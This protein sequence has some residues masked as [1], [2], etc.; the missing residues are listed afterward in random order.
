[1]A[2]VSGSMQALKRLTFWRFVA[3]V[4]RDV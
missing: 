2:K 4:V 3:V 1:L